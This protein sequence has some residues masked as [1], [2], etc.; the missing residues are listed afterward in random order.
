M[1]TSGFGNLG[2]SSRAYELLR[3]V[4]PILVMESAFKRRRN[5]SRH[6]RFASRQ[7]RGDIRSR[8]HFV[9]GFES[10]FCYCEAF[11]LSSS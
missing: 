8:F 7:I 9:C 5:S 11:N 10:P 3:S 1:L 2:V 4:L 6:E